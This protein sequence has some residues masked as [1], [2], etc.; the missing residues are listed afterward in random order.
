MSNL[1]LFTDAS[2]SPQTGTGYGSY[3]IISAQDRF[4]DNF[5]EQ[6]KVKKFINTSSTKLELQTL[7]WA[8]NDIDKVQQKIT[9][10]TDCQNILTLKARRARFEKNQ[11]HS[12]KNKLI[13]NYKHY[14]EF[15]KITD[16]I[17]CEFIKISGHSALVNKNEMDKFFSLVDRASR[18]ALRKRSDN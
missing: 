5:K 3:L 2:V 8:L 10:Y 16:Q 7:L 18:N 17:N 13:N 1:I 15:Y 4:Q 14:Q 6:I 9:I 12:N 11:Y